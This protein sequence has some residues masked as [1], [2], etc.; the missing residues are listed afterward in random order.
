MKYDS[1]FAVLIPSQT[2][3]SFKVS[4]LLNLRIAKTRLRKYIKQRTFTN[5]KH[6][7]MVEHKYAEMSK[8]NDVF[9]RRFEA[10]E[11]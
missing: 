9:Q 5:A 3:F 10:A 11:L 6:C 4:P 8:D 2:C 1:V 7:N